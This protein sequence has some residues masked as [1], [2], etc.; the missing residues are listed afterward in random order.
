M[1]AH[2]FYKYAGWRLSMMTRVRRLLHL[3]APRPLLPSAPLHLL[4]L[5]LSPNREKCQCRALFQ[6]PVQQVTG[7][8]SISFIISVVYRVDTKI[9]TAGD[10]AVNEPVAPEQE[11]EVEKKEEAAPEPVKQDS[12]AASATEA[13]PFEQMTPGCTKVFTPLPELNLETVQAVC[14]EVEPDDSESPKQLILPLLKVIPATPVSV[15][16]TP[17]SEVPDSPVPDSSV[18][19]STAEDFVAPESQAPAPSVPESP[20][21]DPVTPESPASPVPESPALVFITPESPTPASPVSE[22]STLVTVASESQVP[23]SAAPTS[24]VSESYVLVSVTPQSPGSSGVESPA[25]DLLI[26]ESSA[27]VPSNIES[28]TSVVLESPAAVSPAPDSP[29]LESPAVVSQA[30][31][32]PAVP[33]TDLLLPE[34]VTTVSSDPESLVPVPPALV[35]TVTEVIVNTEPEPEPEPSSNIR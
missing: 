17:E 8:A 12:P 23:E 5:R 6:F 20:A 25:P 33:V 31:E 28:T 13:D 35:S 24:T 32:P 7:V 34:S 2:V 27:A 29:V 21:P 3:P 10:V 1:G 18:P 14:A 26:P 30:P 15:S 22:S 4:L 19:E 9:K 16:P 11:E